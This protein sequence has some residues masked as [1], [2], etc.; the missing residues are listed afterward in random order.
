[1]KRGKRITVSSF[2]LLCAGLRIVFFLLTQDAARARVGSDK[3]SLLD[4]IDIVL[5]NDRI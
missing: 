1:M 4:Y 5:E 3:S 2:S